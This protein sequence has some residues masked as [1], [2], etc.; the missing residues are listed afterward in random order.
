MLS[1]QAH[2]N[3]EFNLINNNEDIL[4]D[5]DAR[6]IRQAMTNLLQNAVDSVNTK[7]DNKSGGAINILIGENDQ[8][9]AFVAVT[10]DGMGFPEEE[11]I[12]KLTEPYITHKPKGTGLGLAI[13]KKI[14]E[15]HEG[16]VF[17]G[18]P[19]WLEQQPNW[20]EKEG[21]CVVLIFPKTQDS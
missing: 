1:K 21:A 9:Q 3:I 15:D 17:L 7:F 10:D 5:L 13:V 16:Q 8:N 20:Q 6:Q 2:S 11:E 12:S 14:M 19:E 18:I 4:V